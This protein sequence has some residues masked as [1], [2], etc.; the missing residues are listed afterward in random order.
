MACTDELPVQEPCTDRSRIEYLVLCEGMYGYDNATLWG[1]GNGI[2]SE[3]FRCSNNRRLG[4]TANDF[5]QVDDSMFIIIVSTSNEIIKIN[6]EGTLLQSIQVKGE[7][8]FLKQACIINDSMVAV[9]DLYADKVYTLNHRLFTIDS[10]P[11]SGLCAPDGIAYGKGKLAICNS[12]Y[13][14]F[15]KNEKNASTIAIYDLNTRS[16]FYSKTGVNPQ[17]VMYY[18]SLSSWIVQ[19]AHL[20]T[21]PD[22]LGGIQLFDE[23]NTLIKNISGKFV[24]KPVVHRNALLCLDGLMLTSFT[25]DLSRKDT[26]LINDSNDHW[27]RIGIVKDQVYICNAR[28]Y[29]LPGYISFLNADYTLLPNRINVGI[30]PAKII[31]IKKD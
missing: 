3:I 18:P 24:G 16:T 15:R 21:E 11:I 6:R 28:N 8:H 17:N 14:I 7:G 26:L 29:T 4:D 19:Y 1:I 25:A 12:G 30:N 31:A 27:Y 22:S 9:T 10:L 20:T 5:L 2:S 13:G 23:N